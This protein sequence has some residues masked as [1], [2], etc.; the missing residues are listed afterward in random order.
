M[1]AFGRA[2]VLDGGMSNVLEGMG[3]DLHP[4]LWTAGLLRTDPEAIVRAHLAYLR[5]GADVITTAS[6]Q[7]SIA[8]FERAG[9]SEP[10]ARQLLRRSVELARRARRQFAEEAH[11]AADRLLVAASVGP[12]GAYLA[13]GSEYTGAYDVSDGELRDYHAPR[14]RCLADGGPDLLACETLPNFREIAILAELVAGAGVP[15]W[16]S[17]CCRD[18]DRLHDGTPLSEPIRLLKDLPG[19][20]ALGANC[21][22]PRYVS[23][24]IRRLKAEAPGQRVVVYP[25]SGEVYRAETGTWSG[26]S[27]PAGFR[28]M[29]A[30]WLALGADIVGGCC[31][32]G[33]EQIGSLRE[34]VAAR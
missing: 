8:G 11:V 23:A 2:L 12:Y 1:A 32:I 7:A 29:A 9:L 26:T 30:E 33:P 6:Y 16:F 22:A 34:L 17:F 14:I 24:I 5:A 19:V 10:E 3:C 18:A 28:Q 15:A 21:I 13:D 31:R 4:T 25:N 27:E 20:V